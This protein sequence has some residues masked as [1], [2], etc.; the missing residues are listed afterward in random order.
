MDHL[1]RL[2]GHG[3]QIAPLQQDVLLSGHGTAALRRW[4]DDQETY[5]VVQLNHLD[6]VQ[7]V[8][9]GYVHRDVHVLEQVVHGFGEN[10]QE[11]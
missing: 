9:H 5:V 11:V 3:K 1:E 8:G 6:V 2:N 10:F 4:T 7:S